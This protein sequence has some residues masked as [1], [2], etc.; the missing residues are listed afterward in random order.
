MAF[1]IE[2]ERLTGMVNYEES[3]ADL[4]SQGTVVFPS[5]YYTEL[6]GQISKVEPELN[7]FDQARHIAQRW[8]ILDI[9]QTKIEKQLPQLTI[10]VS[11]LIDKRLIIG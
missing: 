11:I 1:L 7:V 3:Q 2:T 6:L 4:L 8:V 10:P 5:P 9:T